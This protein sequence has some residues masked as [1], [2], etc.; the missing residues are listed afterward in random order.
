MKN[1]VKISEKPKYGNWMP[2][3]FIF[4]GG[5]F[6]LSFAVVAIFVPILWIR[7]VAG[8]LALFCGVNL[9]YAIYAY[10]MF[11]YKGGNLQEKIHNQLVERL[12]WNGQGKCLEIGCGSAPVAI[13]L[14]KKFPSSIIVA[15]DYWGKTFFEYSKQQCYK[16]AQ[17]EKVVERIDFQF[18]NAAHLPFEDESFDAVISNLT[19]HEVRGFNTKERYKVL[20]E[21]L[22]VLKKGGYFAF[23]DLFCMK[24]AFGDFEC[25]EEKMKIEVQELYWED[26]F[27]S[28]QIPHWLDNVLMLKGL[29]IFYGKK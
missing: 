11:S 3:K 21:A 20:L 28:L 8:I 7:I 14:A 27:R 19:F 23:Q 13:K 9:V 29:G 6:S 5:V 24:F 15:S 16:N 25:L 17:I 4:L 12:S 22:R 18:A 1:K 2:K 10:Y 26:S